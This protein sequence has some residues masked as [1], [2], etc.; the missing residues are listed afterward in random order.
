MYYVQLFL[1]DLR[2]LN[3]LRREFVTSSGVKSLVDSLFANS[4]RPLNLSQMST[5]SVG[6][7]IVHS[8]LTLCGRTGVRSSMSVVITHLRSGVDNCNWRRR[9]DS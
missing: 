8:D 2:S 5:I 1:S 7:A 4:A 6:S 9:C 3:I